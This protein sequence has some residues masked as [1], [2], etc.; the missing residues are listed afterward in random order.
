ME[1]PTEF[2]RGKAGE[3]LLLRVGPSLNGLDALRE[4]SPS[5]SPFQGPRLAKTRPPFQRRKSRYSGT[6][7]RDCTWI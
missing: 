5:Q 1:G 3:R 4:P 2:E 7:S 6:I